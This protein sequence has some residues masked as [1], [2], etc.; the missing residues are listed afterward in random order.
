MSLD[1]RVVPSSCVDF[2]GSLDGNHHPIVGL[3]ISRGSATEVGI[4]SR[5]GN[6]ALLKKPQLGVVA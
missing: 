2:E 4:F 1:S 3:E 6:T 5:I